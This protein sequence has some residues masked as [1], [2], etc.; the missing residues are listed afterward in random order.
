MRND[1]IGTIIEFFVIE[2]R[3]NTAKCEL[4][5]GRSR[6]KYAT[7]KALHE[8]F[9]FNHIRMCCLDGSIVNVWFDNRGWTI[10]ETLKSVEEIA[11]AKKYY[12]IEGN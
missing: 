2:T 3:A 8:A 12:K 11:A 10:V 1:T 7:F 5:D 6:T 9:G 4:V